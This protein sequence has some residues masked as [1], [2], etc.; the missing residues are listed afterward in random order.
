MTSW[1]YLFASRQERHPLGPGREAASQQEPS[2]LASAMAVKKVEA[3]LRDE[4]PASVASPI[5]NLMNRVRALALHPAAV[6]MA[7]NAAVDVRAIL[8]HRMSANS[9]ESCPLVHA[10]SLRSACEPNRSSSSRK[11]TNQGARGKK[12][13]SPVRLAM[14]SADQIR[15]HAASGYNR[16]GS[17]SEFQRS[18]LRAISQIAG[19]GDSVHVV[20]RGHDIPSLFPNATLRRRSGSQPASRM[21]SAAAAEKEDQAGPVFRVSCSLLSPSNLHSEE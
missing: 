1:A 2:S 15:S 5:A 21:A 20:H 4:Y 3:A 12:F 6:A 13:Q 14:C 8:I 17:E 18:V 10:C 7:G 9:M 16:N 11:R 19:T